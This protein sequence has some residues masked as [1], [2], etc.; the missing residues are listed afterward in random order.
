MK[1]ER[2]FSFDQIHIL[3]PK[4]PLCS[5][6]FLY[7]F[8]YENICIFF[9]PE[10]REPGGV[11]VLFNHYQV[12][13]I[14]RMEFI[15]KWSVFHGGTLKMRSSPWSLSRDSTQQFSGLRS[16]HCNHLLPQS[17]LAVLTISISL[18]DIVIVSIKSILT[19]PIGLQQESGVMVHEVLCMLHDSTFTSRLC[20]NRLFL[21]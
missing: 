9:H 14:H 13:H 7:L 4:T 10:V 3:P 6:S 15:T 1:S 18:C 16:C 8:L 12:C 5:T 20:K 2:D 11:V 17:D 19:W 21:S